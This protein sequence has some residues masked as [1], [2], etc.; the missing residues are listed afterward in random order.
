MYVPVGATPIIKGAGAVITCTVPQPLHSAIH[1]YLF[2]LATLD[3][4]PG[5]KPIYTYIYINTYHNI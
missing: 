5:S 2:Q 3:T 4:L 1:V